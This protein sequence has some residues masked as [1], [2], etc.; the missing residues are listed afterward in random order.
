MNYQRIMIVGSPGSGKSTLASKI[1]EITHLPLIRLD[2][3]NWLSDQQTLSRAAFDQQLAE[4]LR[5]EN[6]WIIDGNYNRTMEMRVKKADMVIWLK[7][8]RIICIYRVIKRYLKNRGQINDAGNPDIIERDFL[9]F[10][11]D[12]P[13]NNFPQMEKLQK[14][15]ENQLDFVVLRNRQA[16][17]GFLAEI[18]KN[19]TKKRL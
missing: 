5:R 11:W 2:Q 10:I 4:I 7:V 14:N 6:Q 18:S 12:F 19:D 1:A 15:Y 9:K 3:I 8:P 16:V 17:A 13:A